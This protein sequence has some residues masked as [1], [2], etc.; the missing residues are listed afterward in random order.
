MWLVAK[1]QQMLSESITIWW[2]MG[3]SYACTLVSVAHMLAHMLLVSL[4]GAATC[5]L[6]GCLAACAGGWVMAYLMLALFASL[7]FFMITVRAAI[8]AIT[9]M[10]LASTVVESLPVNQWLDDNLSVPTAAI[11]V[12]I[13]LIKVQV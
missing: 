7:G 12:G 4:K 5:Q 3:F 8:V 1:P 13:M 11:L 6:D 2:V 10:C 9:S